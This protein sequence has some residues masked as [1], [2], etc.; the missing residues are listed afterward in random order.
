MNN[1]GICDSLQFRWK[2]TSD[3]QLCTASPV[4]ERNPAVQF[5]KSK[6]NTCWR[7]VNKTWTCIPTK[8]QTTIR[9]M[10]R[11][12]IMTFWFQ[13]SQ[14]TF[15]IY[16]ELTYCILLVHGSIWCSTSKCWLHWNNMR[17]EV[18]QI[19]WSSLMSGAGRN[20]ESDQGRH[21]AR[22]RNSLGAFGTPA[23]LRSGETFVVPSGNL[24]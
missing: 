7:T 19:L 9:W 6:Q 11:L 23:Q 20:F 12:T 1:Q 8:D 5:G 13:W 24:T 16:C 17:K 10:K 18:N 3:F 2:A 4:D 21:T 22:Q 15:V 14:A